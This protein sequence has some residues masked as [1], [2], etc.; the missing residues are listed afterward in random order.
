MRVVLDTD[1]LVAGFRSATGASRQ[2][3][4]LLNEGRFE[5]LAS[6][7][8]MIEYEAVL[9]RPEHLSAIGLTEMDIDKFINALVLK[10]KPV[11]TFYLWRPMLKDPDD[12]FVLEVA[13]NGQADAIVTFNSKDFTEGA[14]RFD[15]EILNPGEML[16]RLNLWRM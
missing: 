10:V 9:K 2:L 13:V 11:K 12:E 15:L 4:I 7:S 5:A 14:K 6:V 1:V 16:R 8:L 3:L